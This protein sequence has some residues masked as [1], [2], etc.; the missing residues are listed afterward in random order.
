MLDEY[1]VGRNLVPL[2]LQDRESSCRFHERSIHSDTPLQH[3]PK[4]ALCIDGTN[5]QTIHLEHAAPV[6][7]SKHEQSPVLRS[8]K[9]AFEHSAYDQTKRLVISELL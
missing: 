9:P 3:Q 6:Y 5:I 7:P 2:T 1:L 4:S 8:H